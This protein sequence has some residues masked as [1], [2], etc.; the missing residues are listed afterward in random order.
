MG[1]G[2]GGGATGWNKSK[3]H[4]LSITVCVEASTMISLC[5]KNGRPRIIGAHRLGAMIVQ[6][7]FED[8]K[9]EGSC[10]VTL[11]YSVKR[12]LIFCLLLSITSSV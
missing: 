6:T 5:A 10:N 7:D 11:T 2:G 3:L 8:Q 1:R 12:M 9:E 4:F